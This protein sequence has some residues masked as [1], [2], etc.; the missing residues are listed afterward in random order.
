ME[1]VP[2]E[3][4]KDFKEETPLGKPNKDFQN[5]TPLEQSNDNF[6]I[7]KSIHDYYENKTN[8][9]ENGE[10]NLLIKYLK[11]PKIIKD[12]KTNNLSL[13][14]KELSKQI[15]E[16][17]KIIL[18]FI[19]PCYDLIEA[20]IIS[21]SDDIEWNKIF[22]L[23]I[24]N[25]FINRKNLIPIY[26]YFSELF[27]EIG[28]ITESDG[29]L[30]NFTKIIYLWKLFYSLS[31]D[32]TKN[33]SQLIS[34]FCF[35]GTGLEIE[36]IIEYLNFIILN[37]KINFLNDDFLKYINEKDEIIAT[38]RKE[39][40][41][42]KLLNYKKEKNED[43]SSIEFIFRD[44]NGSIFV[45]LFINKQSIIV[46]NIL[47]LNGKNKKIQILNNFYGQLK[48][49]EL[50]LL[51]YDDHRKCYS[52]KIFP[53]PLKKN[54]GILYN[55][56]IILNDSKNKNDIINN[57]LVG[58]DANNENINYSIYESDEAS[59]D[60]IKLKLKIKDVNLLKVNYI[61]YKDDNFNI[62]DYFGG[63]TQFLPFLNI[64]NEI[65]GNC[66]IKIINNRKKEDVLI[67]FVT[68]IFLVIFNHLNNSGKKKQDNFRIYWNFYF[69]IL[70]KIELF[71][72]KDIKINMDLSSFKA[73]D[74]NSEKFIKIFEDFLNFINDKSNKNENSLIKTI[75]ISDIYLVG[76]NPNN[77]PN[78]NLFE[79][80]NNQLYRN[81]MKQLFVYNRLWS[82]KS[83]FFQNVLDCEKSNNNKNI[84]IKY[85]R[86]NYYTSNFQ[87]PLIYPILE[88]DNYYPDF[89]KFRINDNLYKNKDEIL[90]YNFSLD[91]FDNNLNEELVKKYLDNNETNKS[92]KCCLI[93][94]MYHVKG[95]LGI[96]NDKI[97]F[98]SAGKDYEEKCNKKN[99][100]K[101]E[102][103]NRDLCYGSIFPCLKKDRKR[104]IFIP[105]D[106]IMF[107]LIRVYYYRPSALEIFTFDN[108]SYYFN[109]WDIIEPNNHFLL[110]YLN[111][112]S[113]L[114]IKIKENNWTNYFIQSSSSLI[115]GMYSQKYSDVLNPLFKDEYIN[116]WKD[117]IYYYSNFDKLMIINLFSNRSF[118][119]LYQYPVFPMLY[120]EIKLKRVMNE[121]IGFQDLTEEAKERKNLIV[122][123]YMYSKESQ[124]EDDNNEKYYFN[125]F[126][127]NITYTCN[128]LIRVFPYSF[129]GIEYQGDGFD[130]P[131]RLFFSIKST[132]F[133]T[134][135][136]RADLR[137]LIPE[138]FYF[139]P[140]FYNINE[141]QLKKTS[142]NHDIDQVIIH[143]WNENNLNKYQFLNK[144]KDYLE[145]EEKLDYW[146]DLIF[147]INKE[148][149]RDNL[150]EKV[151]YY[152]KNNNINLKF[153]EKILKD[154]I[155]MQS[156]D[157]GVL[158]F[159]LFDQK[160]PP[161]K[162][163]SKECVLEIYKFN[164]KKFNEDHIECLIGNKT[165]FICKGE[166]GINKEYYKI[167]KKIK[168]YLPILNN[169]ISFDDEKPLKNIFYLFIGDVFGNLSI[170][171]KKEK[172]NIVNLDKK[173]YEISNDAILLEKIYN[174][175]YDLLK[176]LNDHTSE[177]KY[178]DYNPRLNLLVDYALDGYINLYTMP[179]LKLVHSIQTKDFNINDILNYVL[180][181]SNP[182]PMI[183]CFTLKKI[184]IF[185]INGN[186]I[187]IKHSHNTFLLL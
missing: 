111:K 8:I 46:D 75:K 70:N 59:S 113:F 49:I 148:Y 168:S 118:H 56:E 69:Y 3:S 17:N 142:S 10:D 114:E 45:E 120:N 115:I 25:S 30:K 81:I 43:I 24:E 163:I 150:G 87:Q 18:P 100:N 68:D 91:N 12:N 135:N 119:D 65:Y 72:D 155:I 116:V 53:F 144:M 124:D 147:G 103:S 97:F 109:F 98:S 50:S 178:I 185:D 146:I 160:F 54:G 157:F 48:S 35:L 40:N 57:I 52:K 161:K 170:Y 164:K 19:D 41:Y 42:S 101:K 139:P 132:F 71:K 184:Y 140:L 136:Q 23:L 22:E 89:T 67:D 169:Y 174:N 86:L 78:I 181:I 99:I 126:Y 79:K 177:I 151:R 153:D 127:S 34:S 128:Y 55:S 129:I 158:P 33:S 64:V 149:K 9:I 117:K 74:N 179:K 2:R 29:K 88:I 143:D 94:K 141:L 66:N 108:K 11:N 13:F 7:L 138:M 85:K 28:K 77:N 37:V 156:Y 83:L 62:I 16:G 154:D 175:D 92:I 76:K 60:I 137:E 58:L 31:E 90:S 145:K 102:E 105:V 6:Q 44:I 5:E 1:E 123:S 47:L 73:Y 96:L 166:K 14:I 26:A 183:C 162:N 106:K 38:E 180:L 104:F 131:N 4:D 173:A 152:S 84:K 63:I 187:F 95:E 61:N 20:Y 51:S 110:K 15:N 107:V 21:D 122:E 130:D 80:T 167:I 82:K 32:K 36:N 121:S 171:I 186:S 93:K 125:L 176:Q 172:P 159:Q 134:L 27:L 182:F 39:I 133:N 165:S 112:K